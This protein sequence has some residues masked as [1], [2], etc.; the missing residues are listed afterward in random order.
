MSIVYKKQDVKLLLLIY[1]KRG[2]IKI[3]SYVPYVDSIIK[4]INWFNNI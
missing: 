3:V 2:L 1:N 4:T